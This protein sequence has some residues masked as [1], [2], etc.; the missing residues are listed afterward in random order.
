[1]KYKPLQDVNFPYGARYDEWNVDA[2]CNFEFYSIGDVHGCAKEFEKL[3]KRVVVDAKMIGKTAMIFQHGDLI[4][5]GPYFVDIFN[6]MM[7]YGVVPILGNHEHNF[8]LERL[9]KPCNS[10]SRKVSHDKFEELT[11]KNQQEVLDQINAMYNFAV[12]NTPERTYILSH[13]PLKNM[14][15]FVDV[16]SLIATTSAPFFCMRSTKVD[17]E[18]MQVLDRP[19]TFVYGHQSWEY[20]DIEEQKSVQHQRRA[21][22]YNIDANCVYGGELIALRLSDLGVIRVKSHVVVPKH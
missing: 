1:M 2:S 3:L 13:S 21:Q 19:I 8:I 9:G 11:K 10:N 20:T 22:H 4:D 14:E 6:L 16:D 15:R 12:V 17:E 5:R 18:A 7:D